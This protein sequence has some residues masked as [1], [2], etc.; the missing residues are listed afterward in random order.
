MLDG[1]GGEDALQAMGVAVEDAQGFVH[2]CHEVGHLFQRTETG[3][4]V[5]IGE[6]SFQ[7]IH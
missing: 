1:S 5:G 6:L 4:G 3:W 7:F 2:Y